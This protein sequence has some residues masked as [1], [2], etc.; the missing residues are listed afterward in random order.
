MRAQANTS[1]TCTCS[2]PS[3]YRAR[4]S[5]RRRC[6]WRGRRADRPNR[7]RTSTCSARSTCR[8]HRTTRR[9]TASCSPRR[10]SPSRSTQ[11]QSAERAACSAPLLRSSRCRRRSTGSTHS[12]C[13]SHRCMEAQR[14]RSLFFE[15]KSGTSDGERSHSNGGWEQPSRT[16]APATQCWSARHVAL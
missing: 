14:C 9:R 4:R 13:T 15:G 2:A 8:A 10:S 6:R 11:R 3:S 5:R 7:S 12:S 16:H 1:R